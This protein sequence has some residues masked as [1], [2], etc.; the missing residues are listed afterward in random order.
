LTLAEIVEQEIV[1]KPQLVG[2]LPGNLKVRSVEV[3]PAKI[4]VGN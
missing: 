2:K 1:I 3:L 4:K